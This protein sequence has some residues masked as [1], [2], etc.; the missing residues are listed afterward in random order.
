MF[1]WIHAEEAEITAIAAKLDI[2][3]TGQA[4]G[5]FGEQELSFLHVGADTIGIGA[6][7]FDEGLLNAEGSV[8]ERSKRSD[9]RTL[10]E[11]DVQSIQSR[12]RV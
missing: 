11:S 7:A 6:V 5:T 8:N 3:T 4:G 9:I 10:S 2:D 1:C 12:M